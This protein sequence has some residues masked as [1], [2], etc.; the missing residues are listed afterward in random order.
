MRYPLME[1]NCISIGRKIKHTSAACH[2]TQ[3]SRLNSDQKQNLQDGSRHFKIERGT[4]FG[5]SSQKIRGNKETLWNFITPFQFSLQFN[6]SV[7]EYL[8]NKR[9]NYLI[10][11]FFLW[12]LLIAKRAENYMYTPRTHLPAVRPPVLFFRRCKVTVLSTFRTYSH[13]A[14]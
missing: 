9:I 2:L 4:E 5:N 8:T 7:S 13:K 10:T 1:I 14:I 3:T 12:L 11:G 6:L